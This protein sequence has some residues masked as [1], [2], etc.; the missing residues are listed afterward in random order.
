MAYINIPYYQ[1]PLIRTVSVTEDLLLL[2]TA[3]SEKRRTTITNLVV[4]WSLCSVYTSMTKSKAVTL[5]MLHVF[6]AIA[7]ARSRKIFVCK[8]LQTYGFSVQ[9]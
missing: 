7:I 2:A 4:V 6:F 5:R 8:T 3:K 1:Y 9:T